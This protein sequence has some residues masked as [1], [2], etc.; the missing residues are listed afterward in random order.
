MCI[1][2]LSKHDIDLRPDHQGKT[3]FFVLF[4]K[5]KANDG[6]DTII[7][8][9]N[10]LTL[11]TKIRREQKLSAAYFCNLDHWGPSFQSTFFEK[12]IAFKIFSPSD[13]HLYHI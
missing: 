3:I 2:S 12:K 8:T 1:N 13:L 5:F 4:A 11:S 10:F 7:S 9:M 6:F